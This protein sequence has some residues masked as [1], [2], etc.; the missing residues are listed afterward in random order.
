MS[1][2]GKSH[3]ALLLINPYLSKYMVKEGSI[4]VW[5]HGG[6]EVSLPNSDPLVRITHCI[7]RRNSYRDQ[8]FSLYA[9]FP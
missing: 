8:L 3:S 2:K 4:K 5:T 6:F 1:Q 9:L 7:P